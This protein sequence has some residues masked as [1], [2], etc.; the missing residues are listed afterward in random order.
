M[1]HVF[2]DNFGCLRVEGAYNLRANRLVIRAGSGYVMQRRSPLYKLCVKRELRAETR[3]VKRS[4]YAR[5]SV[6]HTGA[7]SDNML[8]RSV[9]MQYIKVLLLHVLPHFT[10]QPL[11]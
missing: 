8:R 2:S 11:P 5:R 7:M 6:C 4:P 10:L 1:M 9:F 3:R